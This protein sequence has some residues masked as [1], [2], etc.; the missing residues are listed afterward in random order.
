MVSALDLHTLTPMATCSVHVG[1]V[2]LAWETYTFSVCCA[3]TEARSQLEGKKGVIMEQQDPRVT[4][5]MSIL[6]DVAEER[7]GTRW[8]QDHLER[9]MAVKR[10]FRNDFRAARKKINEARKDG[11]DVTGAL[12]RLLREQGMAECISALGPGPKWT[13]HLS[14]LRAANLFE[15]SLQH[16]EN[17]D[18]RYI[19]G[20]TYTRTLGLGAR[21]KA[22]RNLLIAEEHGDDQI[23][24][25]AT[26]EIAR[27][28]ARSRFGCFIA[29]ACY[30]SA[31]H[32]DVIT[33]RAF[34]DDVL[35]EHRLGKLLV[36]IYYE[37]GPL[38]ARV[39]HY[40]P[41]AARIVRRYLLAPLSSAIDRHRR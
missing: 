33:L 34:R 40:A 21:G 38:L 22:L 6:D 36:S 26:K 29:T 8:P 30:G 27:A 5:A 7:E 3:R 32:P 41:T 20:I 24:F 37:V 16:E 28:E 35:L 31:E 19:L 15:K 14:A 9:E 17:P 11:V 13:V 12:A 25:E 10:A 23:R 18:V 1:I 4:V 39:L 2:G